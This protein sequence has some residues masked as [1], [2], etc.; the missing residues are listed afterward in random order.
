MKRQ[1]GFTLVELMIVLLIVA[2][3]T[4]FAVSSYRQS[5][6]KSTRRAA[7]AV[8]MD[9]ANR[10]RQYF[11]ANRAFASKSELGYTL[12]ADL[13]GKYTWDVDLT[14]PT[15]PPPGFTITLTPAGSQSTDV[16]LTLDSN[17][18]KTPADKW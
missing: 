3:L 7:Q 15:G 2:I 18:V 10:E 4:T 14:K 11:I 9:I 6:I 13:T 8:M 1:K 12:P 16:K 17:G 5:V